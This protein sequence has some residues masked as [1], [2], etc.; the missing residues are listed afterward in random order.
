[1]AYGESL[2][3]VLPSIIS[4]AEAIKYWSLGKEAWQG[5]YIS[6]IYDLEDI[7]QAHL[8]VENRKVGRALVKVR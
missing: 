6:E 8:H 5:L 4:T 1:M 3:D 7:V 2:S